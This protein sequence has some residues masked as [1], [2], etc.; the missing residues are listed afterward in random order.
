MKIVQRETCTVVNF[1]LSRIEGTERING[2]RERS[3]FTTETDRRPTLTVAA[4]GTTD[5]RVL[6]VEAP[7]VCN[8]T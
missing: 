1:N 4:Q 5:D 2:K 6:K 7:P 8:A 3:I